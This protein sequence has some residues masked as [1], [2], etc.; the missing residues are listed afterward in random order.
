MY[1]TYLWPF[2][3]VIFLAGC[4]VGP[5]YES[6]QIDMPTEW[7]TPPSE[8]MSTADL[9]CF[10]WW[11]SLRDPLLNSLLQRAAQQ[12]LD[13]FIA[14]HRILEA[15]L[16]RKGKT[17]DLYPHIDGSVTA[18]HLYW[19]KDVLKDA[20]CASHSHSSKR[21]VSFFEAGF[22]ADWEI[23]LFGFHKHEANAA[24]ARL[25]AAEENLSD[26]WITL[27]AEIARNYIELRGLQ[28]RKRLLSKNIENLQDSVHLTRELLT[29]GMASAPDLLQVE[30]QLSLLISQKPLLDLSI[31]KAI[32]RLSILLGYAPGE[33][34]AELCEPQ[35]LPHLPCEKPLG[36][37]SELLRR[38]PDIRKAER[39][40]AAATEAVGSAVA[41]LFPRFSLHGFVGEISTQL[42]SLINGNGITW[43][44]APQLLFPIFNSRL[45]TQDVEMNKLQARQALF[46]YQ[47]TVLAALEEV[48]NAMASFRHEM[49]R[50]EQ[51]KHVQSFDQE[52]YQLTLQL[53]HRGIKD[54][55]EVLTRNRTLLLAEENALQGQV[56]LL[57]HYISLYKALGGGWDI[58]QC[59]TENIQ[60][61]VSRLPQNVGK[62]KN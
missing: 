42:H 3:F 22:D 44:A 62:A 26:I 5:R 16:E 9:D 24:Q 35:E 27:S 21:N 54:Y 32:H 13:L 37:P 55:L 52:A 57:L 34:F 28:Q 30:E 48:E 4:T 7:H 31:D 18:G 17:A 46:E 2:L 50:N 11:E 53:Y 6:P 10:L 58:S 49:E 14:G 1:W 56:N 45:L 12:N 60:Q 47:K 59:L 29:I 33:L 43:F 23:D 8:G 40:L 25:E 39:N 41:A 36:L 15:R 51:L 20:I 38:R 19:S 61:R